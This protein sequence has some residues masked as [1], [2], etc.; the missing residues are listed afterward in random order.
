MPNA[1]SSTPEA[2]TG[3]ELPDW[4]EG[5]SS[6]MPVSLSLFVREEATRLVPNGVRIDAFVVDEMD[7]RTH[8]IHEYLSSRKCCP[9]FHDVASVKLDGRSL[10]GDGYALGPM[11]STEF[12]S[13][14]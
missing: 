14:S 3:M 7:W 9:R 5:L 8:E 4:L 10:S 6:S 11:W 13:A 12:V 1:V 2:H